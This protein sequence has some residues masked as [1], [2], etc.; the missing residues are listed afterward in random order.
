MVVCWVTPARL[1]PVARRERLLMVLDALG[2]YSLIDAYLLTLFMVAFQFHVD[3]SAGPDDPAAFDVYVEAGFGFFGFLSLTMLALVLTHLVLYVHRA[4]AGRLADETRQLAAPPPL[5]PARVE[6]AA[7]QV[8]GQAVSTRVHHSGSDASDAGE[9]SGGA[10]GI[11]HPFRS[12][13]W[14]VHVLRRRRGPSRAKS[15]PRSLRR[16]LLIPQVNAGS[17]YRGGK[18]D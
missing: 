10:G 3:L 15:A 16:A 14:R 2:K 1:L 7:A 8:N 4:E 11:V 6:A 9:L 5:A 13:Y 18:R 12:Q 17:L